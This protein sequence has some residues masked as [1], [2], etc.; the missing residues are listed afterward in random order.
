MHFLVL[1]HNSSFFILTIAQVNKSIRTDVARASLTYKK[2]RFFTTIIASNS[3]SYFFVSLCNVRDYIDIRGI[4]LG[5][6]NE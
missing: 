6:M 1:F 2:T 4:S 3:V 5:K